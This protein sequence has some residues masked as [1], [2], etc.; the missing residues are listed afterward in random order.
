MAI[1]VDEGVEQ[2]EPGRLGRGPV[3]SRKKARGGTIWLQ[4]TADF[5][6]EDEEERPWAYAT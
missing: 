5:P 4:T 1:G 6:P 3:G 2:H